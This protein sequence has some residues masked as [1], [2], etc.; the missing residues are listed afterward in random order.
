M[1]TAVFYDL[2][3]IG[4]S[5]KDESM[6]Q[7]FHNTIAKIRSS[8][9]VDEIALQRAYISKG[10]D[11]LPYVHNVLKNEGI[12]LIEVEPVCGAAR[13]K[14]NMVDFK[15]DVD[16]IAT[17]AA[18]RSLQTIAIASGDRD[19]GFMC[20]QI[21]DMGRKLLIVSKFNNTGEGLVR[22][23][24]DWIDLSEHPLTT[25]FI[26][27]AIATRVNLDCSE[28]DFYTAFHAVLSA[29]EADPL[30]K[31]CMTNFGL[32]FSQFVHII[33]G[34]KEIPDGQAL[35]LSTKGELIKLLLYDTAFSQRSGIVKFVGGR[36]CPTP[37]FL[38]TQIAKLPPGY[39]GEKFLY[40]YDILNDVDDISMLGRSGQSSI[41]A[42]ANARPAL[43]I[44]WVS[45]TP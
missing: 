37:D 23:C 6:A 35:E 38:A 32:P 14:A 5:C 43:S 39:S 7:F 16:V 31:R 42:R 10:S 12:E 19:F 22:I 45:D 24:D 33:N 26:G 2:E 17:V 34:Y 41:A 28:M 36:T 40:Y 8:D 27:K 13:K 1:K 9:I 20:R 25:K 44:S 4:L 18:K 30:I 15:M 29:F 3:N 11:V 21:K